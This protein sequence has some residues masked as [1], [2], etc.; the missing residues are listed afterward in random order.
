MAEDN[1]RKGKTLADYAKMMDVEASDLKD[2]LRKY[3]MSEA[4]LVNQQKRGVLAD[5]ME[6]KW[7]KDRFQANYDG[8]VAESADFSWKE[9]VS[10]YGYSLGVLQEFKEDLKPVFEWLSKQL[11]K[12]ESLANLETEFNERIS[13]TKFGSRPPSELEAD[14][15]R[16][17]KQKKPDF[18]KN[19]GNLAKEIRRVAQGKYG[20]SILNMLDGPK[21]RDIAMSLIYE[22]TNFLA[23]RFDSQKILQA[24]EPLWRKDVADKTNENPDVIADD[25]IAGGDAGTYRT[26]LMSWLSRNGVVMEGTRVDDYLDKMLNKNWSIDQVKQ[27]VR[28][29]VFTRQY[30]AY[31]DL[32]KQG[33]D[34]ADIALDF[35]Q[36]AAS[37]LEKSID[38]IS[39]DDPMVKKAMQY[40][41]QDGKPAQ[42]AL[43]EFEREVRKSP[44]W[45]KTDN[46]MRTYTDIGETI[47]RNFGFRG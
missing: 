5:A 15:A 17:D 16:Y 23:G 24:V 38:A 43:W 26:Q 7:S 2:A 42:M 45:D 27:E 34:V 14:L 25:A 36:S 18:Q 47:L 35:R 39:I 32:F 33:Q 9:I 31:S 13:K 12:G 30:G 3:G 29:T 21:G 40:K 20:D 4:D 28:N 37:L 19:L 46:A 44:E 41:G 11:Q 22:D 1:D 10:Q 6:Q 8:R